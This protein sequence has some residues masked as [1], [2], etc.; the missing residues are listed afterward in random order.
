MGPS[1]DYEELLIQFQPNPFADDFE[2]LPN[3]VK[4]GIYI[5]DNISY[6]AYVWDISNL[7][8]IVQVLQLIY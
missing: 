2:C 4:G 7:K 6:A 8:K 5:T 1:N 3:D